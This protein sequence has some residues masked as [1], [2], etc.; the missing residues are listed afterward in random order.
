MTGFGRA[1]QPHGRFGMVRRQVTIPRVQ[2]PDDRRRLR[3]P[4]QRRPPQP[5]F[6]VEDVAFRPSAEKQGEAIA[7]LS[8]GVPEHCC[9][10]VT[11]GCQG[12]I[13][14]TGHPAFRQHPQEMMGDRNAGASCISQ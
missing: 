11:D 5:C 12:E 2:V 3:L 9:F 14:R 10:F 4:G 13:N 1:A 7:D 8:R 6:G